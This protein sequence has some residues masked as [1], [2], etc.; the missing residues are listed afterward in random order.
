MKRGHLFN[1]VPLLLLAGLC[2][3]G[4]GSSIGWQAPSGA[5]AAA[6]PAL[7]TLQE[8]TRA[9]SAD[10]EISGDAFA[11]SSPGAMVNGS[12]VVLDATAAGPRSGAAYEWALYSFDAGAEPLTQVYLEF[13]PGD[14]CWVAIPDFSKQRWSIQGPYTLTVT[15]PLDNATAASGGV[16][17]CAAIVPAGSQATLKRIVYST[18]NPSG[19]PLTVRSDGETGWYPSLAVVQGNPAIAYCDFGTTN[20]SDGDL[21]YVRATDALG[22]AWGDP[23]LIDSVNDTGHDGVLLVVNGKPAVC[24]QDF[25]SESLLYAQATDALGETW[26]TPVS[27]DATGETGNYPSMAIVNGAPAIAHLYWPAAEANSILRYVRATDADGT[28][29]GS[30]VDLATLANPSEIYGNW[31]LAVVNGRP[32]VAY[33][34]EP[35][36]ALHLRRASDSDG[37]AWDP[38]GDLGVAGQMPDLALDSTGFPCVAYYDSNFG[39]LRYVRASNIDGSAWDAAVLVDDRSNTGLGVDIAMLDG[40]PA[41]AYY[42][43]VNGNLGFALAGEAGGATWPDLRTLDSDGNT[44]ALTSIAVLAD[45]S[46]GIA[47]L[48]ADNQDLRFI[49]GVQ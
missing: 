32:A 42:S 36:G 4:G 27:V 48:D 39:V 41:L 13:E 24:Y 18:V 11:Q 8:S 6:L 44:G 46:I 38:A 22:T 35:A 33:C 26:G 19:Q 9:V 28:A 14:P 20:N 16:T 34:D 43:L 7:S 25:D 37:T 17:W 3:C 31:S 49:G 47:Y 15:L 45:G 12:S 23:V 1:C 5:I 40:K 10:T 21:Y 29:W 2:A 30:P